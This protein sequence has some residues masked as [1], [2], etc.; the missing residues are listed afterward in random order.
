MGGNDLLRGLGLMISD[1]V[2]T[3]DADESDRV[4]ETIVA[5]IFFEAAVVGLISWLGDGSRL[6]DTD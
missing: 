6:M 2:V 5:G 3:S 4:G 1:C